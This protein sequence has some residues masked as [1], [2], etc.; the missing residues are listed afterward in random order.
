MSR[1]IGRDPNGGAPAHCKF[2][3]VAG[4]HNQVDVIR[5]VGWD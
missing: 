5:M 4:Y 2:G 1:I 3:N